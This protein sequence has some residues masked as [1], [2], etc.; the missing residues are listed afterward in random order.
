MALLYKLAVPNGKYQKDGQDKT[1][2]LNIG[3]IMDTQA[4]G[5]VMKLDA[6]PT[7]VMDKEGNSVPFNGWVNVF[8][9]NPDRAGQS[10]SQA[11]HQNNAAQQQTADSQQQNEPFQDVPF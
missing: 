4:G 10:A 1:S 11:G 9:N 5:L 6:I 8:T 3:A 2:W 7:H